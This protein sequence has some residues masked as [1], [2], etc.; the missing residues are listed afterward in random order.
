MPSINAFVH[1]SFGIALALLGCFPFAARAQEGFA[2]I[3]NVANPTGT[4]RRQDVSKLFLRVRTRW[5]QG[6]TSEPMDQVESSPVRRRFSNAIL[7]MDVPSVKGF[8]QEM[9]FSGRADPPPERATDG[10]VIAFVKTHPRA[11]GYVAGAAPIDGVKV[12][13]VTP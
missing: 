7:G 8:W 4:L 13:T 3:V 12:I 2:V 10:D 5:P 11:I 9:V 1:H 6:Q